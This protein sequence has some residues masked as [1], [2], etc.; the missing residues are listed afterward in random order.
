MPHWANNTQIPWLTERQ[1]ACYVLCSRAHSKAN[2]AVQHELQLSC[3]FNKLQQCRERQWQLLQQHL[4]KCKSLMEKAKRAGLCA[5]NIKRTD[6][7]KVRKNRWFS[8]LPALTSVGAWEIK[9]VTIQFPQ[10]LECDRSHCR[11]ALIIG[12]SYIYKRI[13][14]VWCKALVLE[15]GSFRTSELHSAHSPQTRVRFYSS[16]GTTEFWTVAETPWRKRCGSQELLAGWNHEVSHGVI[17][18]SKKKKRKRRLGD[19]NCAEMSPQRGFAAEPRLSSHGFC[20]V[21]EQAA[22]SPAHCGARDHSHFVAS[23]TLWRQLACG[24]QWHSSSVTEITHLPLTGCSQ[25]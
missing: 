23:L 21:L 22:L 11:C 6:V 19:S 15:I 8:I 9:G 18:P 20:E 2:P 16:P 14:A 5:N 3:N 4:L 12:H 17:R 1:A 25:C 24:N 7:T 10:L 13:N